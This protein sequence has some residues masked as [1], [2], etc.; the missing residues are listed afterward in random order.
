MTALHDAG[1]TD[2]RLY[3]ENPADGV[4]GAGAGRAAP[5]RCMAHAAALGAWVSN[6]V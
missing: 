6:G 1:V 2:A 4:G 5:A 3:G